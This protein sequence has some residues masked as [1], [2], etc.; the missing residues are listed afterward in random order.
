MKVKLKTLSEIKLMGFIVNEGPGDVMITRPGGSTLILQTKQ[1]EFEVV[2]NNS[3]KLRQ[4]DSFPE[5][6]ESVHE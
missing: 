6:F 3:I 1:N 4:F 5:I 2:Q